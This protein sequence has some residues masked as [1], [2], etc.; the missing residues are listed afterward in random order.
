MDQYFSAQELSAAL[1]LLRW[2]SE[3]EDGDISVT[4][5]LID[6]NGDRL[7]TIETV[8]SESRFYATP[9]KPS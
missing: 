1:D 6:P 2:H 3:F 4:M 9:N 5:E 7:G 8:N